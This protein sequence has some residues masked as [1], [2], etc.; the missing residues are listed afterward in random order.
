[1]DWKKDWKIMAAVTGAVI[2]I[3]TVL[4]FIVK[5]Q[6]DTIARL[7]TIETSVVESKNIG[8]G[9]V[10]AQSSYVTQAEL[11][12]LL[13]NQGLNIDSIKKDL[14]NLGADIKGVHTVA[15]VTPGYKGIG[16]TSTTTTPNTTPPDSSK[17]ITDNNGYLSNQQWFALNE[18]FNSDKGIV[19]VPFGKVGFSAWQNK[20]WS[21]E[22][23]PRTYGSTT[24]I[25]QDENG[26][27]YAYSKFQI[28]SDGKTY[29]IPI[30]NAKIVEEYPTPKFSFNPRMYLGI[31]GGLIV[32]PPIHAELT[33][34]IGL[35]FFSYGQTKVSPQW[36][37]L[38][39]GLGYATQQQAPVIIL[40]PINY[41]VGK[42]L[43]LVD[44]LHIGPSVSVDTAGN[45]G[46]YLG[47]RVAL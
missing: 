29:T 35:S 5:V 23:L 46:L 31:D 3:I 20:P 36:T 10:R 40:S 32:N 30:T 39:L 17:P 34:N 6:Y 13:K 43:P 8:N 1:M 45:F 2:L 24:V 15:V 42:D 22:V 11:E 38:T 44:N 33:P 19:N 9:I 18:P 7:K 12:R 14:K 28:E 25:G 37:F 21:F 4:A 26:R 41:N 27:H 16:L 47:I